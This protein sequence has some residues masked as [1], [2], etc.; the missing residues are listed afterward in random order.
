MWRVCLQECISQQRRLMLS[1]VTAVCGRPIRTS[2]PT[3]GRREKERIIRD[4]W[5]W[6]PSFNAAAIQ[7]DEN[8]FCQTKVY[9]SKIL[10]GTEP[11]RSRANSL[12]V[13]KVQVWPCSIR[14]LELSLAGTFTLRGELAREHFYTSYVTTGWPRPLHT[15]E[16]LATG[17]PHCHFIPNPNPNQNQML[18]SFRQWRRLG[19]AVSNDLR[20]L[21]SVTILRLSTSLS[22]LE[23]G[24][25]ISEAG[26]SETNIAT[27]TRI[28]MTR[29]AHLLRLCCCASCMCTKALG[30]NFWRS[31]IRLQPKI[32]LYDV[33]ILPI[34]LY[35][36]DMWSMTFIS[37]RRIFWPVL[38]PSYPAHS[39]W[40]AQATNDEVRHM[41]CQSPAALLTTRRLRLFSHIARACP[42][43]D[44]TRCALRAAINRLPPDWQHPRGRPI[45][46]WLQTIELDF[47]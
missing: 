19:E 32:R 23:L 11:F 43:Q 36:A 26:G 29:I 14:S 27:S 44:H 8:T 13:A 21:Y 37:S 7:H 1:A 15:L 30:G 38:P 12:P 40:T 39:I 5:T 35:A 22:I 31:S 33:Y 9:Y 34:L 47:Q 25:C 17:K 42:S 28:E 18:T 46:N 3:E 10:H 24:S 2:S 4:T 16:F 45:Q 20:C 41:T 6:Q